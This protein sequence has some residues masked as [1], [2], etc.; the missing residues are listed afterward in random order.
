MPKNKS[1][2]LL[3]QDAGYVDGKASIHDR[4]DTTTRRRTIKMTAGLDAVKRR[5][6][7]T[8]REDHKKMSAL[9]DDPFRSAQLLAYQLSKKR[10]TPTKIKSA[11]DRVEMVRQAR[12][13]YLSYRDLF[14]NSSFTHLQ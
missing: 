5:H 9:R 7:K 1:I 3:F 4:K 12:L 14:T 11:H 2:N 10:R 6:M 13:R 8:K